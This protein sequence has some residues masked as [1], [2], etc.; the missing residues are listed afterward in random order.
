IGFWLTH[1]IWL[2]FSFTV[3]FETFW[4]A[5]IFI[6]VIAIKA[7]MWA[8]VFG[9]SVR[10]PLARAGL[11]VVLEYLT[12]LGPLAFPWGFMGYA[13]TD[14]PGRMLASAGGI[15]L[16]SLVVLGVAWL[17]SVLWEASQRRPEVFSRHGI[18]LVVLLVFWL[19]LWGWR[20]PEA[21]QG[22]TTALLV[23]GNLNP[24]S[25]RWDVAPEIYNRLS[26]QG[27]AA[28]PEAVAVVWPESSVLGPDLPSPG[29][30]WLTGR[31]LVAGAYLFRPGERFGSNSA[32]LLTDG[33][34]TADYAKT[35]L[36]PFGEFYPFQRELPQVYSFFFRA[37]GFESD[38]RSQTPGGTY[39][40]LGRYGT[41]ICYESV[42]PSVSRI[43]TQNGAQVLALVTNDAWFGPSFGGLQHFQMGRIRAAETG[44]WVLRAGN[45]GVTAVLDPYGRV[46]SFIP[47]QREGFL[48][49]RFSFL[50]G[51]TLYVRWGDWAVWVALGMAALGLLYGRK[52][53]IV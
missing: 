23:Q 41:Y 37:L 19:G 9:L 26:A 18:A 40:V 12:S 16:L 49:G 2:P 29:T 43:F 28:H 17:L 5:V 21:Q 38:L 44:R 1:L 8:A 14:A 15:Y 13:L 47:R 46:M 3:L 25:G 45:D 7:L 50:E 53:P 30:A 20:L 48:A 4:G 33:R 31:E 27:V 36:V 39:T 32:A 11:W 6:P 10:K 34:I 52:T 24:R 22:D 42:F 35:R 51:Q